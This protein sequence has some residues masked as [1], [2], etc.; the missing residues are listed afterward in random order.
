ML[1]GLGDALVAGPIIDGAARAGW[2][3]DVAT[4]LESVA[5]YARALDGIGDVEFFDLMAGQG[6]AMPSALRLR[7]N[8]YDLAIV[9]FPAARWQ[10]HALALASAPASLVTHDYGGSARALA[11][12][13]HAR[14]VALEGGHRI[15]ENMRLARAAGLEPAKP[16]YVLPAGWKRPRRERLLGVHPGSMR[17]KGNDR[18]RWPAENFAALIRA[19]AAQ[20]RHVRLFIGPAERELLPEL[21]AAAGTPGLEVIDA[22]LEHAALALSECE[23]FVGNDAGFA[24]VASGLG[25]KT[26]VLYGMTDPARSQ[27]IGASIA[28]RPSPCPPCHD[29]GRRGFDCV[30][31]IGFR[32]IQSDL[33]VAVASEAVERAFAGDVPRFEPAE[34][35][36]YRLFGRLRNA[37]ATS[38]EDARSHTIAERSDV[39]AGT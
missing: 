21:I 26:V 39:T 25:V 38:V 13:A 4:M 3:L 2:R 7:R 15:W 34:R 6:R 37:T 31:D 22:P 33:P 10:Y 30:L 8:K 14:L 16:F 29:E 18:K 20:G 36:A 19:S 1:P 12:V 27:P 9:P 28:V 11:G 35:G 17:Y 24:H 23:V 5:E 32:C